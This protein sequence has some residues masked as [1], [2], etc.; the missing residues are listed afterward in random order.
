MTAPAASKS[1][2]PSATSADA[3]LDAAEHLFAARGFTAVP[4]KEVA[5]KAGVNVA[6]I[7]Y[8]HDSKE[9]LYRHVIERFVGE[10]IRRVSARLDAAPDAEQAIRSVTRAQFEMLSSK[11]HFPKLIVRELVDY[12]ASH[13][14]GVLRELGATLFRR[15]A[16][17]IREGQARGTF[18]A[19][20]DPNF[21]AFSTIAQLPYFY[22]ARPA[23]GVLALGEGQHFDDSTAAEFARHAGDFAVA[24]LRPTPTG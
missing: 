6:L 17:I 12:Q 11:P 5:A 13:A 10:L 19:D 18:R 15:L 20:L 9:A 14:V 23:L 3:I 1:P 7:Y 16:G 21:A 2:G 22:V 8:Y 4:I 24:A